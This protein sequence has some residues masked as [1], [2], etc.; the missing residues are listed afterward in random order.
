MKCIVPKYFS[1]GKN[2]PSFDSFCG[3]GSFISM[4]ILVGEGT[5]INWI[6]VV[7]GKCD[8]LVDQFIW[9]RFARLN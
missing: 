8:N 9:I 1:F 4:L 5:A 3:G 2:G 7:I 6:S